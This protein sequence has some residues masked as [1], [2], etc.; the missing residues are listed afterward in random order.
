VDLA[1]PTL[2]SLGSR[3]V[4]GTAQFGSDYGVTNAVGRVGDREFEAI[5]DTALELG[6]TRLDTA[7]EYGDAQVRLAPFAD[8]F[9]ITTKVRGAAGIT[10]SVGTCLEQ[11]GLTVLDEVLIHD[12]AT[13]GAEGQTDAADALS[14]LQAEG[15]VEAIGVSVYDEAEITAALRA[16]EEL[17]AVQAPVNVVDQRLIGSPAVD[18]LR[19]AGGELQVR[20][21]LLQGRL[22]AA[23]AHPAIAA[24]RA[25]CAAA[26]R[27]PLAGAIAFVAAQPWVDAIVV[28]VTTADELQEI[29]AAV[30]IA[31]EA[32]AASCAALA[33]D[34]L[35]LI[36]PRTWSR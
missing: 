29:A 28:G 23:D 16:F 33:S 20:S 36:D 3:L 5:L 35:A 34:D 31:D 13:L 7:L 17:D 8:A 10:A 26:G 18:A 24:F 2:R 30:D 21:A 9:S 12:W 11:L 6:I 19:A 32:W 22:A 4:L 27:T 15:M 1:A 25:H 14:A